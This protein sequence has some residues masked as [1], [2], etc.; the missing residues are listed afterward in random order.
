MQRQHYGDAVGENGEETEAEGFLT[1][2]EDDDRI[3]D[4]GEDAN[5][6]G[7]LDVGV[8]A[9][10]DGTLNDEEF[11]AEDQGMTSLPPRPTVYT[12]EGEIDSGFEPLLDQQNV[13]AVH[14]SSDQ[15]ET[16]VACGN[17][18]GIEYE[19]GNEIVIGLTSVDGSQVRGYAVFEYD[20]AVFGND[21]TAVTV[22]VF[23]NMPSQR[24]A[25]MA[26]TPAA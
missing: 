12:A 24:D 18:G 3:L 4:D 21:V 11:V 25:R 15:Y 20:T 19:D 22:H 6:N 17:V 14:Q 8:D 2:D 9:D 16:I 10:D 5:G 13:I 23:E 26:A 1:E 7:V